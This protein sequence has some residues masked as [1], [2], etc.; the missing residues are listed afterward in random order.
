MLKIFKAVVIILVIL[1]FVVL[2]VQ[3]YVPL[4]DNSITFKANLGFLGDW[5][6]TPIPL[7]AIMPLSFAAGVLVMFVISLMIL[8]GY[9]RQVRR[10]TKEIKMIR[11]EIW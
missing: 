8:F 6:L 1:V 5:Q 11:A 7:G 3:N 4:I 10:L 2:G 9:S